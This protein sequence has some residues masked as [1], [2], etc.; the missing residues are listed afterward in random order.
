M[1]EDAAKIYRQYWRAYG[2]RQ[3]LLRSPYLRVALVVLVLT[4]PFW[5]R[6]EWWEQVIAVIPSLL[7]FTLGGFAMFLGFGDEKF[8]ALLAEPD[9]D[10]PDAPSLFVGLCATFVH[11][12][13]VQGLALGFAVVAKAWAFTVAWPTPLDI[14]VACLS[15]LGSAIG[16]GLFLYAVA[17]M[18][19]ATMYVFR[20]ATWY[21]GHRRTEMQEQATEP[22]P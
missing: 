3:A 14:V 8:R 11:F 19:A 2:G 4:V 5:A 6:G 7:G 9:E 22:P 20:V 21:E 16:Y 10:D 1:Q 12:I 13:L 18:M 17:S 15:F